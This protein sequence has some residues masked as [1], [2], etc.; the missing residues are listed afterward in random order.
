MIPKDLKDKEVVLAFLKTKADRPVSLKEVARALRINT[1]KIRTLKRIL[2]SLVNSGDLFK[3]RS[4]LYGASEKM[5]LVTGSFEAHRDGYGFVLPDKIGER[6]LF[7]PPR[8]TSGAMSGDRVVVRVE[9]LKKREGRIIKI[10]ERGQHRVV[11][12]LCYGKN[13]YYV[14]PKA[15]KYRL[16][17]ISAQN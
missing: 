12:K 4:G 14:R 1:K 6:D 5:N 11:G 3:T 16:I 9:S 7:I 13:F 8:K 2:N 17:F 10:L 15:R